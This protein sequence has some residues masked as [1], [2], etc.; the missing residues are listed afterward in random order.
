M[1]R[2]TISEYT[3]GEFRSLIEEILQ[4][5]FENE[6]KLEEEVL[7]KKETAEFFNVTLAT[8]TNWVKDGWLKPAIMGGKPFFLKTELLQTLKN[9]RK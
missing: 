5:S 3:E 7:S 4:S 9:N 1:K 8:I 6:K 2:I